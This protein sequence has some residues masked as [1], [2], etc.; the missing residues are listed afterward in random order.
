M[1]RNTQTTQNTQSRT[2][3]NDGPNDNQF[4]LTPDGYDK[5][6]GELQNLEARYVI[7]SAEFHDVNYSND[8]SKEEAAYL[9]TRT[10]REQDQER[11][12][13]LKL[14]L[15]N[16]VILDREVDPAHVDPGER[17]TVWDFR[18]KQE[19]YFDLLG[20]EEVIAGRSGVTIDSPVGKAL[21]GHSIGDVIE[22]HVP[23][24][25]VKYAIRNIERIPRNDGD[26]TE[27]AAAKH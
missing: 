6:R 13:H 3:Q 12:G 5:L 17:V 18:E 26:S 14:I 4:I 2:E 7:D 8:P 27:Q 20:P 10:R 22:V 1:D 15:Q 21:L 9:E 25:M 16:A 11:I 24:G 23:D 19:I